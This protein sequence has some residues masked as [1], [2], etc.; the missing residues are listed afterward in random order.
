[1]T[2]RP[3]EP[4]GREVARPADLLVA[5]SDHA[6]V[7]AALAEPERP[8]G[9]AGGDLFASLGAPRHRDPVLALDVD[10]IR[11]DLG[12]GMGHLAIAHVVVRRAWWRGSVIAVM[13]VDHLGAWNVAPRA[14]PN[15]GAI[16]VV[17]VAASMSLRDRWSARRRLPT[18]THVP[19]P[20][21]ATGRVTQRSW[22]FDAPHRVW[23][24]GVAV[25]SSRQVSVEVEPDRFRV[26]V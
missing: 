25:G 7:A 21:I 4:W 11:V 15:D 17:E 12:G 9:L 10:A 14:H 16:D 18:G 13:N 3:G 24:D 2:I 1:M 22:S 20:A 26:H 23:V 8:L 6:A 19:H 5:G